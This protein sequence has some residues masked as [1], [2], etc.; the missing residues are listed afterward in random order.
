MVQKGQ[1]DPK[2]TDATHASQSKLTFDHSRMP[3]SPGKKLISIHTHD[4]PKLDYNVV[5]YLK[6]LK[7]NVSVMDIC[8]IPQQKDLLL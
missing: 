1:P 4:S 7:D 5:E 2:D 8:I 3:F 6:K